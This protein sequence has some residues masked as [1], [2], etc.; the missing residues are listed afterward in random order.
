MEFKT[1]CVDDAF[2]R[3]TQFEVPCP[4]SDWAVNFIARGFAT[5]V[6]DWAADVEEEVEDDF[7][8]EWTGNI[9]E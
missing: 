7:G 3:Q 2:G 9:L 8:V 4:G 6:V 1:V 5:T